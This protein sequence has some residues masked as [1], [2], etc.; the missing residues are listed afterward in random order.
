[1]AFECFAILN[2]GP[3]DIYTF[4]L[5]NGVEENTTTIQGIYGRKDES[6]YNRENGQQNVDRNYAVINLETH[7]STS[8]R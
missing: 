1:M 8:A 5:H 2:F 6:I 3:T 4:Y 7:R